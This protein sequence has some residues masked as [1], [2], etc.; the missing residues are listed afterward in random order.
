M[1]K[2]GKCCCGPCCLQAAELPTQVKLF[3]N[4]SFSDPITLTGSWISLGVDSCCYYFASNPVSI[5]GLTQFDICET[6]ASHEFTTVCRERGWIIDFFDLPEHASCTTGST[7]YQVFYDRTFTFDAEAV[8][9]FNYKVPE[10]VFLIYLSKRTVTVD[11]EP[12][13]KWFVSVK[14]QAY[15]AYVAYRLSSG[16]IETRLGTMDA[17]VL[18]CTGNQGKYIG[19]ETINNGI[20]LADVCSAYFPGSGPQPSITRSHDFLDR[21]D[22]ILFESGDSTDL[23]IPFCVFPGEEDDS[24]TTDVTGWCPPE[25]PF[26]AAPTVPGGP[27]APANC[28]LVRLTSTPSQHALCLGA[29]AIMYINRASETS[30][31]LGT[32]IATGFPVNRYN[33]FLGAIQFQSWREEHTVHGCTA[34][35]DFSFPRPTFGI[36]FVW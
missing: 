17:D 16:Y 9:K 36:E 24:Y 6:A 14:I 32:N 11:Y 5:P 28:T 15:N 21:P 3:P 27:A 33:S 7:P 10:M 26:C 30:C 12:V 1:G 19:S 34:D 23:S 13:C 29:G 31:V 25:S 18:A 4:D 20:P 2:R 35:P 22:Q 8:L